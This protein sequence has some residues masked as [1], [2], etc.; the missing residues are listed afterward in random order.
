MD[1]QSKVML[2]ME[3]FN[4]C[5]FTSF[6]HCPF[7][8]IPAHD[9]EEIIMVD[10]N[11]VGHKAFISACPGNVQ[12]MDIGEFMDIYVKINRINNEVPILS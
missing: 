6:V 12:S 1:S 4:E 2:S 5:L 9:H 7:E 10:N 11:G 3:V 8:L